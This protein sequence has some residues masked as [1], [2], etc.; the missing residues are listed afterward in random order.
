MFTAIHWIFKKTLTFAYLVHDP[1][2]S[3]C[4][5]PPPRIKNPE[6][7]LNKFMFKLKPFLEG[8]KSYIL[9]LL[10]WTPAVSF[11][12]LAFRYQSLF[13]QASLAQQHYFWL[14]WEPGR[15]LIFA[16][17]CVYLWLGLFLTAIILEQSDRRLKF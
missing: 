15:A 10:N 1:L 4:A 14:L 13:S 16:S 2:V 5:R 6:E 17:L 11:S 8:K 9:K 7:T 3:H 12:S